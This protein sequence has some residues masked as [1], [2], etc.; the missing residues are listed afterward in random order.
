MYRRIIRNDIKN[1]KLIALIIL[2]FVT[3]A[4]MLF[5]LAAILVINLSGAID[6]LMTEAKTPHFMQMHSGEID[7][8]RLADFAEKNGKVRDFQVLEFLNI[9][10]T[11]II[12]NGSSLMDSVQD[13]G[14]CIQSEAFDFLLDM[15]NEIIDAS[16][17]EIYLPIFLM[18]DGTAKLYDKAIICGKEF[19]VAGFLR[20]SQMNSLLSTSKRFLI[21]EN[22]YK[23]LRE[24]GSVEYLIEFILKDL[25]QL[26]SFENDYISAKL[27]S[28][29]PIIT[30]PLFKIVN[31]FSDGLMIG[32]ILLISVLIVIIGLM[33]I[34]F[35][36]LGKIEEDFR[37]IGVMKAIGLR[38]S[39]IKKIYLSQYTAIALGGCILGYALSFL[40]KGMLLEN[41]RLYMGESMNASIDQVFGIIGILLIFLTI[42]AY[43]NNVLKRFKKISPAHA[44]HFGVSQEGYRGGKYFELNKNKVLNTNIFLGMKDVLSRKKLYITM[45]IVLVISAFIMILPQN[46]YNTISSKDFF[47]YMGI[48]NCKMLIN[49]GQTSDIVKKAEEIGKTMESD[50]SISQYVILT[51]KVFSIKMPDE[52][53]ELM[54]IEL[55]NHSVFP[56]NYSKGMAPDSEDEIALS[57][58]NADDFKKDIGD[59]ITLFI[60]GK[61]TDLTVCGIYPDITNGGKT[62]KAVFSDNSEDIV[63][64][65]V[66]ADIIDDSLI[67]GKISEYANKFD[68]AKVQSVDKYS[69]QIFGQ[70]RDA[71]RK[72]STVSIIVAMLIAALITLLFMK[73]LLAKDKYSISVMKALGFT[74]LDINVQY[75]WRSIFVL[76]MGIVLG[77]I[78]T[79]TL[80]ETLARMVFSTFGASTFQF[81]INSSLVYLLYPMMLICAVLLATI[82]GTLGTNKIMISQYIKE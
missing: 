42:I 52:S 24:L 18:K 65:A 69:E 48:G 43:V 13:N 57:T 27:E 36:L 30:Y 73:M 35:T 1:N 72:A 41:I 62:A 67:K 26:R 31:G 16:D 78:F 37:E 14:L 19:T 76:V 34:R 66:A 63:W 29:G 12:I 64:C 77:T 54:K 79:N 80:G 38:I 68:F 22:D 47:R 81:T 3:A 25:S 8:K 61:S 50:A 39:D 60:D 40:F 10:G 58:L 56:V 17:G 32:V 4:T 2:L 74:S 11:K 55:G 59:V 7:H 49:I 33:C 15:D 9:D 28:N 6:T 45:L 21:S 70:T 71:I 51:T 82:F 44:L 75:I 46:L 20:D 23:K 53:E 5:S